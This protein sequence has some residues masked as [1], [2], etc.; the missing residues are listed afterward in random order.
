MLLYE[1]I[2]V[3]EGIDLNKSDKSKEDMICHY[4]YFKDIGYKYE[5]YVCNGCHDLSMVVY[6]LNDFMILNMKGID[7]RCVNMSKND[8]ITLLCSSVLD[9]KRVL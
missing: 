6:D 4:W 8:A 9:N 5:P 3:S 7:Y 1:R 2:D